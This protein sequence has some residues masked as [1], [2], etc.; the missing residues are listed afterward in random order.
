[1]DLSRLA[2]LLIPPCNS[3]TVGPFPRGSFAHV[4]WPF[5]EIVVTLVMVGVAR[6][7]PF[8]P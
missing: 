8:G 1:M 7:R 2:L 4:G 5:S 3:T 6:E